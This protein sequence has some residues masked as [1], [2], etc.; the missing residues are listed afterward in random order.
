MDPRYAV[1]AGC[2]IHALTRGNI[3]ISG[4]YT[5]DLQRTSGA[6][7]A[8]IEFAFGVQ[9]SVFLVMQYV[10]FIVKSTL[11]FFTDFRESIENACIRTLVLKR[12]VS[13]NSV[14]A[15]HPIEYLLWVFGT[16]LWLSGYLASMF[17]TH[18]IPSFTTII[19]LL[20]GTGS[21]IVYWLTCTHIP[22]IFK[23]TEYLLGGTLSER[24]ICLGLMHMAPEVYMILYPLYVRS[25][26]SVA[27]ESSS[28]W[29]ES[30]KHL[31]IAGSIILCLCVVA[32]AH[33]PLS[34]EDKEAREAAQSKQSREVSA[35]VLFFLY[36]GAATYQSA[37]FVPFVKMNHYV[38][39][40]VPTIDSQAIIYMG[41]GSVIGRI[42]VTFLMAAQILHV[43]WRVL[44]FGFSAS[45]TIMLWVWFGMIQSHNPFGF[46]GILIFST[47]YGTASSGVQHIILLASSDMRKDGENANSA[48]RQKTR[49]VIVSP[50]EGAK[51]VTFLPPPS[52]ISKGRAN[53]TLA[54]KGSKRQLDPMDEEEQETFLVRKVNGDVEA[55]RVEPALKS[56]RIQ[57]DQASAEI[58]ARAIR[59]MSRLS[60]FLFAGSMLSAILIRLPFARE[61]GQT[62]DAG[63]YAATLST[64]STLLCGMVLLVY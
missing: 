55:A 51:S 56:K 32:V 39:A 7:I 35:S 53:R 59:I 18:D 10:M 57:T 61:T 20:I 21:G 43:P 52:S 2:V 42:L 29:Y 3:L 15:N 41:I 54:R 27:G 8:E 47:F 5:R 36:I 1:I 48:P 25:L 17:Y 49:L 34:M 12:N 62:F 19:S 22:A 63:I 40:E 6:D 4:I 64:V 60:F 38:E 28:L 31:T 45:M 23:D 50:A 58:K 11:S 9:F 26:P 33:T 44:L 14:L 46:A 13:P 24:T 37:Y 30:A 16:V